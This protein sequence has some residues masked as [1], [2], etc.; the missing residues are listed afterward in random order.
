MATTAITPVDPTFNTRSDDL[1]ALGTVASAPAEGWVIAAGG[2]CNGRLVL[3]FE[4]DGSG[5]TV[6]IKAGDRPPAQ[7]ADYGDDDIVLAASDLRAYI[8]T[9]RFIQDDS[10]I[11]A[12]CTDGGTRC[13][14]MIIPYAGPGY[15][16]T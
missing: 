4:A 2:K 3:F 1:V 10:T 14:A 12:V 8:P 6:T 13:Y 11:E 7:D 15:P 16:L 9:G 5:D